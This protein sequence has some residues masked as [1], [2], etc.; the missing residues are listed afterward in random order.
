MHACTIPRI[1]ILAFAASFI[2]IATHAQESSTKKENLFTN[3]SF[4]EGTQGWSVKTAAGSSA[5]IDK[6]ELRD[7]KPSLRIANP[8]P[9]DTYVTQKIAVKPNT[10]YRVTAYITTKDVTPAKAGSK[11]GPSIA[12]LGGYQTSE[13]IQRTKPWAKVEL[14]FES[15]GLTEM[16]IGPRVGQYNSPVAG[17]AWFADVTLV[18]MGRARK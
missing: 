2:P 9:T 6:D 16:A 4:A 5:E 8:S 18:E 12:I 3:A 17:T 15:G 13:R 11:D 10:R 1:V 14:D 7:G